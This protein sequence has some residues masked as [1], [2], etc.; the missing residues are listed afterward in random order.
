VRLCFVSSSELPDVV[1]RSM[2][3]FGPFM[4]KILEPHLPIENLGSGRAIG[5]GYWDVISINL[6]VSLMTMW[7]M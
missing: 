1:A 7:I 4:N 6:F 2:V 3:N 5:S